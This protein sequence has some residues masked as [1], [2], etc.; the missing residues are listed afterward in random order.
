MKKYMLVYFCLLSLVP[1]L[2]Q[3]TGEEAVRNCYESYKAAILSDQGEEAIQWVDSRTITYYGDMLELVKNADSAQLE[4]L[5]ILD[6][7]MV[8]IIRHKASKEDI[9]SFD[10]RGLF[11]YA[12][13]E[14]M[15]GKNEVVNNTIGEVTIEDAFAKG[16]LLV[17]EQPTPLYMDFYRESDRWKVDLTSV[18]GPTEELFDKLI[19]DS[20]Q[21]ENEYLFMLLGMVL[22][23]EPGPEIWKPLE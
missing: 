13:K 12:I 17:Q 5:S 15:V 2:A 7:F 1:S 8:L 11:I 4:T 16:Q 3:Q 18:F 20:G 22:G 23:T 6:K 9:L 14:G 19:Q 21:A 10:G